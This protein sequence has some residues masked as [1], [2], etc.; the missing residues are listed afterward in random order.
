MEEIGRHT[1]ARLTDAT[2]DLTTRREP[3]EWSPLDYACHVRD[4]LLV[5][6]DWLFVA[7]V[8]DGPAFKPMYRDHRV[9][10]DRYGQ[11]V[12]DAVAT[13]LAMAAARAAHAFS[14]LDDPQWARSLI[15]NFPEP[16][17][18]DVEWMTH[19]RADID[20]IRGRA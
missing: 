9:E 10:F 3:G 6:R 14:G 17:P 20:R 12:P 18:H 8:E 16:Q 13:Q 4:V 11:Q 1:A 5:Q 2:G 7:L 15:D 19:H